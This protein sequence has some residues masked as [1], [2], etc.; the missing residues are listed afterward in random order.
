MKRSKLF[1]KI[2]VPFLALSVIMTSNL[3]PVQAATQPS[4]DTSL[5]AIAENAPQSVLGSDKTE[6]SS[7]S[8]VNNLPLYDFD[9]KL[10]AY[11]LDLKSNIDNEKAYVIV[12]TSEQDEPI[13]EFAKGAYSPYD[14]ITGRNKACIYDG[15]T[16][17]YSHDLSSGKYHDFLINQDLTDSDVKGHITNLINK[18]YISK[19]PDIAKQSRARLTQIPAKGSNMTATPNA[20]TPPGVVLSSKILNVPDY[21]WYMG[22]SPTSAAMVL[23]YTFTSYLT[24]LLRFYRLEIKR[25]L[26]FDFLL[27]KGAIL[28]QLLLFFQPFL[29]FRFRFPSAFFGRW[30]D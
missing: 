23:K 17:Y 11:S 19:R 12:S 27:K 2:L 20:T 5:K 9:N 29:T 16:G 8:I 14:K 4:I 10:I 7:V 28:F 15:V 21:Q 13:L 26:S 3:V 22:C 18:K 25:E 24:S 1:S 30:L 6:W